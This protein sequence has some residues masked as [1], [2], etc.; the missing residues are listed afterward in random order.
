MLA[1]VQ[2][3]A[4]VLTLWVPESQPEGAEEAHGLDLG[5]EGVRCA[6]WREGALRLRRHTLRL[7]C[8]SL[9]SWRWSYRDSVTLCELHCKLKYKKPH[10]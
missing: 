1:S 2:K 5:P 8:V 6:C 4:A 3:T 10:S 7:E 9:E